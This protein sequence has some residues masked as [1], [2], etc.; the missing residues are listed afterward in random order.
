M[1][2][3]AEA[4]LRPTAMPQREPSWT[5]LR[6]EAQVGDREGVRDL[7]PEGE[8]A[9]FTSHTISVVESGKVLNACLAFGAK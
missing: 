3:D 1:V 8:E 5:T 4:V 2:G 9:R 6:K 7:E